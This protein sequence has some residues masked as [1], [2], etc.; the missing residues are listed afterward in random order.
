MGRAVA[1][2]VGNTLALGMR[3]DR[4]IVHFSER[5][6]PP[7][8]GHQVPLT[9]RDQL[10]YLHCVCSRQERA[11]HR[12]RFQVDKAWGQTKPDTGQLEEAAERQ[13]QDKKDS[14]KQMEKE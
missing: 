4:N 7:G 6:Q 9:H 8:L 1:H 3:C 13:G 12:R 2:R 10:W 5:A 14:H 11:G